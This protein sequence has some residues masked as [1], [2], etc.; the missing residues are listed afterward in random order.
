[1]SWRPRHNIKLNIEASYKDRN[2]WLLHQEDSNFTTFNSHEWQPNI[3]LDFFPTAKQQFRMALQWVGVR[4]R[5][6]EFFTLPD[7]ST[8]LIPGPKP[9]GPSD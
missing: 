8:E 4:A 6:D 5:E 3:S 2:G 7:G 9:P 1:M